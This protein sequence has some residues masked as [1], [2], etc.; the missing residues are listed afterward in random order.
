[1]SPRKKARV[2]AEKRRELQVAAA[3]ARESLL[4]THVTQALELISLAGNRV[5]V[6][7]M[8]QIYVRVNAL[9]QTD[10]ELV[11][12]RLLATLGGGLADRSKPVVYVEGEDGVAGDLPFFG[13]VRER[14]R[15]RTLNDLRRSVEL[16]TGSTQIALLEAHVQHAL[17]FVA[18]LSE[19][20]TV[21]AALEAYA[22]LVV[23]PKA[24]ADILYVFVLDRLALS[25]LPAEPGATPDA[26]QVPL[27]PSQPRRVV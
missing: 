5:S 1:M 15:G 11:T 2:S 4:Q 24:L 17:R 22:E 9:T 18:M 26:E 23:V 20:H 19:T 16:H 7:R 12:T 10:A 27:F 6:M 3:V 13:V 8:L 14:L 25:E 21:S